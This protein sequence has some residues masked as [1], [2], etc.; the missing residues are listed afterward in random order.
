MLDNICVV[1]EGGTT[2]VTL[3][4]KYQMMLNDPFPNPCNPSTTLS[5][6]LPRAAPV[7]LTIYNLAGRRVATLINGEREAGQHSVIWR[8]TDDSG[9]TVPSGMYFARFE[10]V[11]R[12]ESQKVLLLK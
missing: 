2:P 10:A 11:G 8:G 9:G 12:V 6:S 5:F 7:S 4:P 1:L 3:H